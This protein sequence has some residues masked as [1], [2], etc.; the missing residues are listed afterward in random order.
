MVEGNREIV[1]IQGDTYQKNVIVEGVD[2]I[3]IEAIYI[4]C[5]DLG[6]NQELTLDENSGKYVF[7]MSADETMK[8]QSMITTFDITVYFIE[9]KVKTVSYMARVNVLP[10][11]NKVKR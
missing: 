10:K 5:K 2:P 1:V 9:G 8:L 6:I 11:V 3:N 7:I 4:S